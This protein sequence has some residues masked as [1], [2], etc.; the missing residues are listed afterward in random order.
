MWSGTAVN[1]KKLIVVF[2]AAETGLLASPTL[3]MSKPTMPAAQI[4]LLVPCISSPLVS[5]VLARRGL[6]PIPRSSKFAPY[7]LSPAVRKLCA[8]CF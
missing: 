8:I 5:D 3:A 1:V 7:P 4:F 6:S 2:E